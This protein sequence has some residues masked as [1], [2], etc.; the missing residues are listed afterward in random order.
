MIQTGFMVS[1]VSALFAGQQHHC[2]KQVRPG[3]CHFDGAMVLLDEALRQREPSP[4]PPI[5][6]GHQRIEDLSRIFRNAGAVVDHLQF[7]C[8][9]GSVSSPA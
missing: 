2:E 4:L 5:A 6:A 8:Q 9:L 1:S 7:Q 3:G